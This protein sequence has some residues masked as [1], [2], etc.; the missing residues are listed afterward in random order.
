MPANNAR[1]GFF[2]LVGGALA[3]VAT[4]GAAEA[5]SGPAPAAQ[6]P[7]ATPTPSPTLPGA[8]DTTATAFPSAQP[9][10][11]FPPG[12]VSDGT[13]IPRLAE[14][15]TV[16]Q[17][18][19]RHGLEIVWRVNTDQKLVALTFDDGPSPELS[20]MLYD[21]LDE[22]K[23]RA[24]F[25]MVGERVLSYPEVIRG[26]MDRHEVA[27]HTNSHRSLFNLSRDEAVEELTKAHKAITGVVGREPTLMRPPFGH[28]AGSTLVAAASM[29]YSIVMWDNYIGDSY[30]LGHEDDLVAQVVKSAAPGQVILGHDSGEVRRIGIRNVP[31]IIAELRRRGYA[32]VTVS[33]L[34]EA[35]RA[36]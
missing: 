7:A 17:G 26:R 25:F 11:T 30:Y 6:N 14:A 20:P 13:N 24:T 27:N 12:P 18:A 22:T 4:V 19:H 28:V 16:P 23:T 8:V 36:A 5:C 35:S 15:G 29:G 21:I 32:F 33:E 10:M 1:R 31:R 34:M 2:R 3:G 9:M